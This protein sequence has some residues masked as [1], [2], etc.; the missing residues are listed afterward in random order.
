[1]INSTA[2]AQSISLP[3]PLGSQTIAAVLQNV[4]TFLQYIGAPIAVIMVLVGAF[5]MITSAGNP[6]QYGKGRETLIWAAV[7][8][9]I[10]LL[11]GGIATLIS[12]IL[13][14]Q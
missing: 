6:E 7:G 11:A 5:Q 4:I 2:F 3:N 13:N 1:M 10:V 12:N 9:A 14:G 8:F